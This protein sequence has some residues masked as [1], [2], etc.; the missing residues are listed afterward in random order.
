MTDE[1]KMN[2][3]KRL[4]PGLLKKGNLTENESKRQ[5]FRTSDEKDLWKKCKCLGSQT[6]TESEIN[7]RKGLTIST[8]KTLEPLLKSHTVT[9]KTKLNLL[10]AYVQIIFLCNGELCTTTKSIAD[11]ID[12]FQQKLFRQVMGVRWPKIVKST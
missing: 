3:V 9:I 12:S 10:K 4:L 7:R 8:I 1:T 5:E 2:Q 6:D 11:R